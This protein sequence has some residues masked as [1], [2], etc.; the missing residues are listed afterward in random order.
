MNEIIQ[1]NVF[2]TG[3]GTTLILNLVLTFTIS[4]IS[5]G[6]HVGG[7]LGGA[8]C[9]WVMM[10]PHWKQVPKSAGWA[11]P[12]AVALVALVGWIYIY[13][14]SGWQFAGS[15][16]AVVVSGIAAFWVWNRTST[17]KA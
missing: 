4:G 11:A 7:A 17:S 1:S 8:V 16:A 14:A 9:G 10:A 5:I 15:G 2:S 3:I 12:V 6:G 13:A